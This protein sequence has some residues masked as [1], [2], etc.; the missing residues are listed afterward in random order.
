MPILIQLA[1]KTTAVILIIL[2]DE[3]FNEMN[4]ALSEVNSRGA[5]C[6]VI[7]N[8]LSKLPAGKVDASIEIEQKDSLAC[9]LAVL[10]LQLLTYELCVIMERNPDKPRNLAKCVTVK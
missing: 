7:T 6:I 8:C 3:N 10:P 2:D 4:L 5:Y 1:E 9:L